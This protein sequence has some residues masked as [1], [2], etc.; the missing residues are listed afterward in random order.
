MNPL[1]DQI[2]IV[3]VA[4]DAAGRLCVQPSLPTGADFAHIY[5]AAMEVSWD[6]GSKR[7]VASVSRQWTQADWFKQIV[8][9][10]QSEYEARLCI[11]PTTRWANVSLEDRREIE[12][13]STNPDAA[14]RAG[15]GNSPCKTT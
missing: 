14:A 2:E 15:V 10:M 9:A 8:R 13:W 6:L 11:S 7:L 1:A 12:A 5:R 3:E 4:V